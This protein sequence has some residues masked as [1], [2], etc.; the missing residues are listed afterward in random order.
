M[1]AVFAIFFRLLIMWLY[2]GSGGSLLIVGLFHSAFNMMSGRQITPEFVP[3]VDVSTLNLFVVGVTA[4]V[5]VLVTAF[6][7]GRLGRQL[8]PY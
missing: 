7:K 4:L 5:A 1:T 2:N 6:T 8:A 3:S